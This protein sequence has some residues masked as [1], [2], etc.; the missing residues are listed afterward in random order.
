MEKILLKVISLVFIIFFGY[1]LKKIS[2]F[3]KEDYKLISK[4]A[5]NITLPAATIISFQ[6][7]DKNNSLIIFIFL[8]VFCNLILLQIGAFISR[9][10]DNK[11]RAL[12]IISSTGYNMGS[13][14]I[15]FL[16][17]ILGPIG[18]IGACMF[19]TGNAPFCIGGAYAIAN[20]YIK[21]SSA[22]NL[23]E[24]LLKLFFSPAFLV[25]IILVILSFNDIEIPISFINFI[26][27][28]GISNTFLSM[29]MIGMMF[30][31]EFKKEYLTQSLSI[32]GIRYLFASI[33]SLI[34]YNFLPFPLDIR[35]IITIIMFAP[36]SGLSP[37]FVD[38]CNGNIGLAGFISSISIV[39]SVIIMISLV[40]II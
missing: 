40:F 2:F 8:G 10:K 19:D 22:Q 4:I 15:P 35:K 14:T 34:F 6:N 32:L 9:N 23:K 16:S 5:I 18:V 33:M 24:I 39:I 27:P 28:I 20:L 31:I 3:K 26:T 11:T 25:Y 13:F 21:N 17:N 36:I 29:L 37:V 12:Y 7:F 30:E 1:F 38:K